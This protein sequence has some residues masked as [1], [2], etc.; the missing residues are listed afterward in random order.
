MVK[1][2]GRLNLA[3]LSLTPRRGQE[4]VEPRPMNRG[5]NLT[6]VGANLFGFAA[7]APGS[8]VSPSPAGSTFSFSFSSGLR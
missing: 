5:D 3:K 4:Y 8:G 1:T 2:L 7:P 6:L